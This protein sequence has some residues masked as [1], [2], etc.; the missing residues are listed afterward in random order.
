MVRGLVIPYFLKLSERRSDA[1][2]IGSFGFDLFK[3]RHRRSYNSNTVLDLAIAMEPFD[4][5]LTLAVTLPSLSLNPEGVRE[6]KN[7]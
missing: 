4:L 1:S 6:I 5:L 7:R 2:S 3:R